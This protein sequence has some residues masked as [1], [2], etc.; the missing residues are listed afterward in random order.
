MRRE[1]QTLLEKKNLD[2]KNLTLDQLR[3]VAAAYLK[4]IMG[5]FLESDPRRTRH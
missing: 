5:S 1:L 4:E 2:P 3:L